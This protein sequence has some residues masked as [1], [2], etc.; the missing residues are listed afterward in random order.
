[1][2]N[3]EYHHLMMERQKRLEQAI[4]D[5]EQGKGTS[6]DWAII[7]SECGVLPLYKLKGKQNVNSESRI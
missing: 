5:A 6:E 4:I 1:M 3:S 7:C 2:I